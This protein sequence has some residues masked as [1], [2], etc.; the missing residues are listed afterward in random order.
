MFR[1]RLEAKIKWK[2]NDEYRTRNEEMIVWECKMREKDEMGKRVQ[3]Y[4]KRKVEKR[5]ESYNCRED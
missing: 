1:V 5:G 4:L 3:E 2:V